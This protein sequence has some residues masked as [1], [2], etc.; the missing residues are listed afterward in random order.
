VVIAC[1]GWEH[2]APDYVIE[3]ASFP[4][5]AIEFV[6]QGKGWLA[7]PGRQVALRRGSL[8]SY[9]GAAPHRFG[10]DPDEPLRKYFVDLS[11][12]GAA[13]L[14]AGLKA[15]GVVQVTR[16]D[17]VEEW[18]EQFLEAGAQSSS[19]AARVGSLLA[20]LI[21]RHTMESATRSDD[22]P[23]AISRATYE[24]C[25]A[26]LQ[27]DFLTLSSAGEL[28]RINHLDTAYMTRLFQKVGN[29]SPY[30]TLVRL[31]MNHAAKRLAASTLPLKDIGTEVGFPD[32]YH[33]SR[34][35]K[36]TFGLSPRAFR[37][38]YHRSSGA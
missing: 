10:S 14:V 27:R 20:E 36:R 2:C 12:A 17:L 4:F 31:K 18:F 16:A 24:R 6:S 13:P 23:T 28:A 35:F 33:F 38:N 32:P 22:D 34:V 30:Q 9:G 5:H 21:V 8:F 25:R 26:T 11:G 15:A 19:G 7:L 3:R 1:G 29:T 37:E